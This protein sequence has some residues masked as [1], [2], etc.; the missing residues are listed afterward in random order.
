MTS[1]PAPDVLGLVGT[2]VDGRYRVEAVAGRGGHGIVYRAFHL[3]FGLP[4]ALKVL[5]FPA[6]HEL[7]REALLE[8]LRNEGRLL[9]ELCTL[10][11]TFVH[12][13][14]MG[15]LL[16]SDGSPTPYLVLEWLDGL[17]LDA[18]LRQR[19]TRG[20]AAFELREVMATLD[21]AAS[22]LSLAHARGVSH[23]DLKPGNLFVLARGAPAPL[24]VLDFGLAK[25]MEDTLSTAAR[26]VETRTLVHS[27]THAYG[28]PEQ[29]SSK[30]GASG[31]WT[32]VHAWALICVELLSG[33][34]ALCGSNS[35]QLMA[36]CLDPLRPTPRHVGVAVTD[37]VEAVFAR[38]LARSPADRYPAMGAFWRDLRAATGF[39]GAAA[40]SLGRLRPSSGAPQPLPVVS[41]ETAPPTASGVE[42][43]GAVR[44]KQR[45]PRW[46][47]Q[48]LAGVV[49]FAAAGLLIGRSAVTAR[50][51]GGDVK[52]SGP[53]LRAGPPVARSAATRAL[54]TPVA[55]S[56]VAHS[57]ATSDVARAASP[58]PHARV[59]QGRGAR[60]TLGPTPAVSASALPAASTEAEPP[61]SAANLEE[62][63]NA[64]EFTTRR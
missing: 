46:R 49:F 8:G 11:P 4:V 60:R 53:S 23:R 12:A 43:L 16:C 18:E 13:K 63:L 25:V 26:L 47:V 3:E 30:L 10:H 5:R 9:S 42:P 55:E 15:S 61:A 58:T 1:S 21:D 7:G 29:W 6:D 38:A 32:D 19:R 33:S 14:E 36:A 57:N 54:P 39:E 45:A 27:F 41:L 35:E 34:P 2:V 51:S 59:P 48:L 56:P 28:A 64:H 44:L 52:P 20:E 40:L 24:K 17:A 50:P 37:A 62:L 31:P 22:G